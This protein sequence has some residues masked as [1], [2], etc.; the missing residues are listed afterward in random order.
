MESIK[1]SLQTLFSQLLTLAARLSVNGRRVSHYSLQL[2]LLAS[3]SDR[4]GGLRGGS[5]RPQRHQELLDP[6]PRAGLGLSDPRRQG[7]G[8][9]ADDRR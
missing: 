7:A 8:E 2:I 4:A 3:T 1:S 6:R 5:V 9:A